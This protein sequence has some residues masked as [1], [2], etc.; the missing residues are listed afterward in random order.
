[1]WIATIL[2]AVSLQLNE[3]NVVGHR[4]EVESNEMHLVTT[5]TAEEVQLLPV[6]TVADLLQYIPGLDVR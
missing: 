4:A 3:V 2:L 5:L 6:K 1:M